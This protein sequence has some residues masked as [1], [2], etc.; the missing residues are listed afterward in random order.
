MLIK[1][2]KLHNFPCRCE[3]WSWSQHYCIY[4]FHFLPTPGIF[5][6]HRSNLH[7][8]WSFIYL[9]CLVISVF[10]FRGPSTG[11]HASLLHERK[12]VVTFNKTSKSLRLIVNVKILV[13]S[14]SIIFC[15]N[16]THLCQIMYFSCLTIFWKSWRLGSFLNT[17][18]ICH[19]NKGSNY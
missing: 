12:H 8:K 7:N 3:P 2:H 11:F 15:P 1:V 16:I 13:Q 18:V 10:T 4:T 19:N 6:V 9:L 5:H 14:T 17:L